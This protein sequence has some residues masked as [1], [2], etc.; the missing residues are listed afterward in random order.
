MYRK[1]FAAGLLSLALTSC[2]EE[3]KPAVE[4]I[5]LTTYKSASCGCCTLWIDH[6]RDN[7]FAVTAMDVDDLN[8]VKNRHDIDPRFQSCHTS[9]SPEGYVFEG[10]IPAKLVRR[11]LQNPPEGAKGLAVPAMPP[12][13]PGMEMGDRFVPY[14]VLQINA[15]GSHS[16]YA[17]INTADQQY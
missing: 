14:Q 15:D 11:F 2:A 5:P 1:L 3:K 8:G 9:V 6:A 12:G 13:S 16:V 7:G 10:H 17:E 4:D